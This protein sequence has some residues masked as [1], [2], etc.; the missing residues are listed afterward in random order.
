[1]VVQL[2]QLLPH[3][4]YAAS[5]RGRFVYSN[6]FIDALP[7]FST[8]VGGLQSLCSEVKWS[9][10]SWAMSGGGVIQGGS[11]FIPQCLHSYTCN[12]LSTMMWEFI[13]FLVMLGKSMSNPL[14]L[15]GEC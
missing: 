6:H 8:K 11:D 14:L 13:S 7:L 9:L 1:L 5:L 15:P 4:F 2:P 12:A 10:A 3:S